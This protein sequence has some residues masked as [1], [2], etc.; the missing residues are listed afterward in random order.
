VTVSGGPDWW[1]WHQ[2]YDDPTS[3]LSQ[4]LAFVQRRV[5]DV[6]DE[7]PPGPV[8][9]VS[10]CA[11][12]GRDLLG[13]LADHPRRRDVT[14]RLVELDPRNVAAANAALHRLDLPAVAMVE[15]DAGLTDSYTGAVPADL[16]LACGIFG[17][18]TDDDIH[19]IVAGLPAFCA[20]GGTVIWTR[21]RFPPDLTGPIRGWFADEHFDEVGFDVVDDAPLSVG[22]HR[23][24]G[25]PV[26]L[27]AGQ[28]LFQFITPD[29]S[30]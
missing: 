10:L 29:P 16:V 26:P 6:L 14:A 28:R 4:R 1:A 9:V 20:A 3:S 11:G 15:G 12:Q 22:A 19:R 24:R 25:G 2:P 8:R 7:A 30:G 17:N 5:R 21:H 23:Y 18:V 27:P 13:V